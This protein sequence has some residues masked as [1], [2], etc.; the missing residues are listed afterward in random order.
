M[1]ALIKLLIIKELAILIKQNANNKG[2]QS[3]HVIKSHR[4]WPQQQ[5]TQ[6]MSGHDGSNKKPVGDD[7]GCGRPGRNDLLNTQP[8]RDPPLLH[9]TKQHNLQIISKDI[10]IDIFNYYQYNH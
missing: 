5:H 2:E 9:Q 10:I 6:S 3:S 8:R 1:I 7:G 4:P